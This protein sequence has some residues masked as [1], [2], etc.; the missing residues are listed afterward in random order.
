MKGSQMNNEANAVEVEVEQEEVL[1]QIVEV[2]DKVQFGLGTFGLGKI[3]NI[4]LDL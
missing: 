3:K 2:E 1:E 4:S